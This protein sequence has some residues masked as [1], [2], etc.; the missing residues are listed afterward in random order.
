[1]KKLLFILPLIALLT[2]CGTTSDPYE[3]RAD[4][5]RERQE[6]YVQN[7]IKQA[8]A[9]MIKQPISNSAVYAAADATAGNYSHAVNVA[10]LLAQGRI[11]M[12][13]GGTVDQR[14]KVY[15]T[16]NG[17][18]TMQANE[19]AIRGACKGVNVTG[20]EIADHKVVAEGGRYHAYVLV[21]LPTG[22]AN[23]LR[24][25]QEQA[26]MNEQAAVRAEKAFKEL[27]Q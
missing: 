19:T 23:V 1:M 25:A 6:K 7:A 18:S 4:A 10:S 20:M 11:C 3:R 5:D 27:D 21:V 16:D 22:D 26:K 12:A 8:P 17:T 9:W 24:K 13:A 2:A 14:S 15:M